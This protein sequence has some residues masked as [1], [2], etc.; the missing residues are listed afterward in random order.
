M[1]W[2]ITPLGGREDS[3]SGLLAQVQDVTERRAAERSRLDEARKAAAEARKM[4]ADVRRDMVQSHMCLN[5][6]SRSPRMRE[7]FETLPQIAETPAT[8]LVCGESG[9]G[10]ELIARAIHDMSPRKDKPFVAINCSA[11]PDTLLESELF[12]YKAGA[13]TD[14]KKDKPGKFALAE[15]GTL[16]LDEIGDISTAMQVKLLRVLQERV[17]EPLGGTQPVKADVRIVTATNRDLPAQVK[18]GK[19]REDLYYRI[20]VLQISLPPLRERLCD[21]PLLCQ[22]FIELF[23]TR[24]GKDVRGVSQDA[25]EVLLA[26]KYPGNIREFENII[27]H[28]FI[29]CKGQEIESNHLPG[30]VRAVPAGDAHSALAA[31]R[32]FDEL[33]KIYIESVLAETGG[34]KLKA[35][36]KLG[37]HKATLFRKIKRL[38]ISG[39]NGDGE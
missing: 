23:N 18:E 33:E 17:Y 31:V 39:G 6:V 32:N 8:V 12:G 7:V 38:G 16:F 35:A 28:A 30:D 3:W 5:M 19:F 34:N 13:F 21:I 27:E 20:K 37:V 15:D 24:Y 26:H 10:K 2:Y 36:R 25:L 1:A 11:L 4:L 14:A 22:H 9:T 29:F